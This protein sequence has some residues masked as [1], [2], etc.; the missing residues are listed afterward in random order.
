MIG[1][2][3]EE[4][5][6]VMLNQVGLSDEAILPFMQFVDEESPSEGLDWSRLFELAELNAVSPLTLARLKK[7][8]RE[9]YM[10]FDLL[11]R[12]EDRIQPVRERNEKR[13]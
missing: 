1:M 8:G 5:L 10:P 12:W 2:K 11:A 4:R 13:V 9:S 3:I 6:L 7:L